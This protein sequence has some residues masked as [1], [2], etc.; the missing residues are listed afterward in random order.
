[1]SPEKIEILQQHK[2]DIIN[3]WLNSAEVK[4]VLQIHKVEIDYFKNHF[5]LQIAEYYFGVVQRV[6]AIGNCPVM[7]DLIHYLKANN[8]NPAQ[9]FIL[10][11]GFREAL[12]NVSF[13]LHLIDKEFENQIS[14]IFNQNF[15]G[16]L[17]TYFQTIKEVEDK[18]DKT[19]SIVEKY[20]IISKTNPDG[21]ITYVSD[22]FCAISGYSREELIGSNHN[23]IRHPDMPKEIFEDMWTTIQHKKPWHGE[24]KNKTKSG[25]F[26]WVDTTIEPIINQFGEIAGYEAIRQNITSKKELQSQQNILIEQSK[27]AAMGEMISMIA[28]QWRQPL[29]A[30]SILVQKLPITKMIEGD[31]TEEFIDSVVDDVG[32]QLE[33]MSKTIDDF[34]DFFRPDKDKDYASI[35]KIAHKANEFLAPVLKK[36]SIKLTIEGDPEIFIITYVNELVQ[37]LINIIKNARDVMVEKQTQNRQIDIHFYLQNHLITIEIKD[38]AGGI[39]EHLLNKIFEP[40]FSTKSSKNGTGLGL[41]MSKTIVEKH[42][43]G[44]INAHNDHVG[45]V[46]TITLPNGQP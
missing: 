6:Y 38:N 13:D 34:R 20:I 29:Q 41:Y 14:S 11:N 33:Y 12:T 44:T 5:A 23:I 24:V 30:V 1:M 28:H 21:I 2:D 46:F 16:V 25:G 7:T 18:L 40:Y 39:P 4:R 26:Y 27:S 31:L 17:E 43:N 22:A 45:A 8:F 19:N 15:S 35:Y 32:V 37:V 36:D 10:C 9:L 3:H 42:C